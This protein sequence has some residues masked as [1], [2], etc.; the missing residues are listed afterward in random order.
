MDP[1][2]IAL[3]IFILAVV[4]V[5][6]VYFLIWEVPER[7]KRKVIKDRLESITEA[8]RRSPT[9]ELDLIKKELLSDVPAINR[10][11]AQFTH[12]SRLKKLIQQ[13]DMKLKVS[14]FILISLI[15][16]VVGVIVSNQLLNILPVNLVIG[17]F[18]GA[19]PFFFILFKRNRRYRKFEEMFPEALDLLTRAVRA[20]HTFNT[21]MEMIADEMPD[22]VGKEF[23]ITFDEQNF[24]LP[25]KQALFNMLER[26][27]LIDLKFF[28]TAIMMQKETGGNLAE[29]LANL[30][31]LI[32][33]RFKIM[34]EV[35]TF[36]AQGRLTGYILTCIPIAMGFVLS[37]LNWDYMSAL[38]KEEIGHYMLAGAGFCQI[39][40]YVIIRKIVKIKV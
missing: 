18:C 13:A 36:S 2:L 4:F 39:L 25:L 28:V 34:G 1:I 8:S 17:A 35:R 6:V 12:T 40:G 5:G 26:V 23:R 30:A 14:N 15:L 22:P 19:L 32:R 10:F 27:P 3:G 11:L 33:E 38:F 37:A 9:P 7:E 16:F 29:I 20:G 31:H 24:G 21:G